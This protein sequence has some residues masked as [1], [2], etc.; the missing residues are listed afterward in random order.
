MLFTFELVSVA[1]DD[2]T[3]TDDV[4]VSVKYEWRLTQTFDGGSDSYLGSSVTMSPG[5]WMFTRF[6]ATS[7]N[8][9]WGYA[10]GLTAFVGAI[11]T[12]AAGYVN[13]YTRTST[14]SNWTMAQ[15]IMASNGASGNGFGFSAAITYNPY[16]STNIAI[17]G[18]NTV[19]K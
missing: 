6:V 5:K 14:Q 13:V 10:D 8:V 16:T 1:D 15:S 2:D 19:S 17:V 7:Y 18:A 9:I 11:P 12:G 4:P 3:S